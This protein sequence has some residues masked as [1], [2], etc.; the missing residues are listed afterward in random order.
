MGSEMCIRDRKDMSGIQQKYSK[1]LQAKKD[2]PEEA[3]KVQKEAQEKMVEAV[4]DSGLELSTYNQIAQLAQ[5]D[6]DFRTRI[7][8]KM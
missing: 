3:M 7:Q 4:K 6:A 8:E 1:E 5:Y 2:K